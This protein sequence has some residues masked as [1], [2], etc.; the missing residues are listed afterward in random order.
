[1]LGSTIR[2]STRY[3]S[4][5][6][7]KAPSGDYVEP[8]PGPAPKVCAL[9]PPE[10][11]IHGIVLTVLSSA[12][13]FWLQFCCSP[14]YAQPPVAE[15]QAEDLSGERSPYAIP[16]WLPRYHFNVFLDIKSRNVYVRQQVT[17][18]NRHNRPASEL[19]FNVYPRYKAEGKELTLLAK[20]LE[21]LRTPY[22]EALDAEGQRLTVHRV[23]LGDQ[24][25][26]FQWREDLT[27]ALIVP[28]PKPVQKHEAVTV[29]L[30]YTLSLPEMQGRWG[31]YRGV[32]MLTNWYPVLA[33]YDEAGWHPVPFVAWHQPF[34]QEAGVYEVQVT[35][36]ADQRIASTGT[37][38]AEEPTDDGYK[39]VIIRCPA[40]RDFCLVCSNRYQEYSA[41]VE[42]IRVRVLA[43]PEHESWARK[44]LQ[45]ACDAIP[46]Y[47]RWFGPYAYEEFDIVESYFP[48]NGNENGGIIQ[49]DH[50][51]FMIPNIAERY[52]DHL[53][54]H[55]TLHQW[56]YNVVGTNGYAETWMDEGLVS[57]F[58]A[59]RMALKYG[60]NF[61]LLNLPGWAKSW[62]PNVY[63]ND[64]RLSGFYGTLARQELTPIAQPLPNF[65]HVVTL[66]SMTY[67]GGAKVFGMLEDRL[68]ELAFLD[69]LRQVYRKYYFRILH[70]NDFRRE[71]EAY[72]GVSWEAFF[73]RWLYSVGMTDWCI[74]WVRVWA[75]TKSG[76]SWPVLC[77]RFSLYLPKL[78]DCT[79]QVEILVQQRGEFTE[80]TKLLVSFNDRDLPPMIIPLE[81]N[82][83]TYELPEIS[84]RVELVE[85]NTYRITLDTEKLPQHVVIDPD[86]VLP[87]RNPVNNYWHTPIRWRIT[88]LYTNLDDTD[89]TVP[90]DGYAVTFGP[91]AG[92][93]DPAFGQQPYMGLRL[94]FYR[95]QTL[96]GGVFLA[97][98][99][100]DQDWRVGFDII[101]DHFPLPRVQ[102][103]M[104]YVRSLS[105]DWSNFEK[106]RAKLF[107]RY[108]FTYTPS[109]YMNPIEFV[110]V[111]GRFENEFAG[112]GP[113]RLPGIE[114]YDNLAAWGILYYRDY[115]T[116]YWDP[117]TG[118][119]F[120]GYYENGQP[121]LGAEETY[122]RVFGEGSYV[123]SFPAG[124]GYLSETRIA[125]RLAGGAGW[126]DNG[127]HFQLG[128]SLRVRGLGRSDREG[129][130]FWLAS[131]EWRF[132]IYKDW[133]FSIADNI[134]RLSHVY[135]AVFYDVGAIY[136]NGRI[137]DN[138]AHSVGVG[139]RL[140]VA[141]LSFIERTT[142]RFDV[143]RL[144]GEDEPIWFWLGF[145]HAF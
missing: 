19:V 6:H 73:Q 122:H 31:H 13:Y 107:A 76:L 135:G 22:K 119:R 131:A 7:S 81:P 47:I 37:I 105:T 49:I 41:T 124:Y 65:G 128:G 24:P 66:F 127:Q 58:T 56:W 100:N 93:M 142:L 51:V 99:P 102:L 108:I 57:Y 83:E 29:V 5:T 68:G 25:L 117:D 46:I 10:A 104:Q 130:A 82:Q 36:P 8:H 54:S 53:I 113:R 70:I 115:R 80:P 92:L 138:V 32:T 23:W 78:Q 43:F 75:V 2:L 27:T 59:K 110:E 44:A 16:E 96:R 67:D 45:F 30:D 116:P 69:F 86:Q 136:L 137:V 85:P 90:Y 21:L 84:A 126:P 64:Y 71:L 111:Y 112:A 11:L 20:T 141:W 139:L 48:W 63:Y 103:G 74:K 35:L 17:F 144:V 133:Q 132:P 97:Y 72:T 120:Y 123:W 91:W 12:Y 3:L 40:A 4:F 118:Y 62:A 52:L 18:I 125:L 121:I 9:S 109:F 38:V 114:R 95:L 88:P 106:D 14:L 33:Y 145:Q 50:R 89:L 15:K 28:L 39:R 101:R 143:A 60:K 140:D 55:E 129:S 34:Y 94:G 87:D 1:M 79:Y 26:A 77:P 98:D 42:G 61:A 134:A